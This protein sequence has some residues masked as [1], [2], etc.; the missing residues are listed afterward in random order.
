M[1]KIILYFIL[2]SGS[3]FQLSCKK[4]LEEAPDK[5]MVIPQH[6]KDLHAILDYT[7]HMM[8]DPGADES[9]TD[10]YY[11]SDIDYSALS[12]ESDR[13]IYSWAPDNQFTDRSRD[14][15][16]TYRKIYLANT[17]IETL[18][19]I[20]K[21]SSNE[22]DWNEIK[23]Q[24]L[25]VRA[26]SFWQIANIWAVNY[27][28]STSSSDLGI[29]LKL[30]TDINEKSKRAS[31]KVTYDQI[32]L[33]L[34]QA[35]PLLPNIALSKV[36]PSKPAAYG[37]LSRVYMSMRAYS[38]AGKYAD[39][40]LQLFNTL[41]DYNYLNSV[42]PSFSF[43]P[44]NEETIFYSISSPLLIHPRYY[45]KIDTSLYSY[46]ENNDLRKTIFFT[47]QDNAHQTFKGSYAASEGHFSGLA[48]DEILLNKAECLARSNQTMEAMDILNRL[49]IKRYKTGTF[50]PLIAQNSNDALQIILKERRKELVMR[51]TR[52]MDIK[53]LNNEG[54]G[55]ILERIINGKTYTLP[56]N[57]PRYALAL[58]EDVL[59]IS[60]IEQN[61][62]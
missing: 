60:G 30:N 24:A 21:S 1:K 17:A 53:R 23:G 3:A 36:R 22:T 40:C 35:I 37:F 57:D 43:N 54:A 15:G 27:D 28:S 26:R 46:Y 52:W 6:L 58:P 49:L 48:T 2:F 45:A 42:N 13:R 61:H 50:I 4:Q 62:R 18:E 19:L 41:M 25:F 51:F 59:S 14:W 29:P 11:I 10:N 5:H 47:G 34:E 38:K 33:D 8:V 55:I 39:S 7:P 20:P 56:P 31:M 12:E 44:L 9:S 32:I 16:H